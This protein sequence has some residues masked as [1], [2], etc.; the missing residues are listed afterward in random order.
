MMIEGQFS[1]SEY[2]VDRKA[3]AY[4]G[5]QDD[6]RAPRDYQCPQNSQDWQS[7]VSFQTSYENAY[8][9]EFANHHEAEIHNLYVDYKQENSHETLSTQVAERPW[10]LGPAG[11]GSRGPQMTAAEYESSEIFYGY[12][13]SYGGGSSDGDQNNSGAL[14]SMSDDWTCVSSPSIL[15]RLLY[16]C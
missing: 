13:A 6:L 7:P 5:S 1:D 8:Q 2:H 15:C 14:H 11:S 10:L 3:E 4:R 16:I 12:R 9:Y